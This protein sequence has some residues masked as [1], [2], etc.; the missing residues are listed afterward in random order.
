LRTE[1]AS[2]DDVAQA[3]GLSYQ[4]I[5]KRDPRGVSRP[6]QYRCVKDLG[7]GQI[8]ARRYTSREFIEREVEKVW[9]KTWQY[10]CREEEIPN[11]GDAYVFD[12]VGRSLIVARQA[13][14]GVR[15]FRNAC[16]H[17]GRT[18]LTDGGCKERFRCAYHGLAWNIDGSFRENP[19][20]WDFTHVG[21]DQLSLPQ[22]RVET[23]AGFVF[24]NFD[25]NAEPLLPLLGELPAHLDYWRIADCYKAAHIG[26][27]VPANWKVVCEAF[28]EGFH[29][30]A[31][32]PQASGYIPSEKAQYDV[33]SDH[34]TRLISIT[35]VPGGV[36]DGPLL[37][38]DRVI[39]TM[40]GVGS[41]S[42]APGAAMPDLALKPGQT[43]RSLMA[44]VGRKALQAETG[45]DFSD[46][47]DA[48]LLDGISYDVFPNFAPWGGFAQKI[49]YR[50]RP[51]GLDHERT[52]FEVMLLKIA[53]K[54]GPRPEPARMRLLAADEQWAS[55]TELGYLAGIFD[56]DEANMGPVQDGLRAM[57]EDGMLT[58]SRY[59]DMRCRNLHR[60][61]DAYLAR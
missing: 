42:T 60:M 2:S 54:D 32:H 24:V 18:L 58:F 35:G 49:V 9:L 12:L 43:A 57:G 30:A 51:A 11:P 26:K 31:T 52:L 20:A 10:A 14:G 53:P 39:K 22:A 34:V 6:L 36:S 56:Q 45:Y 28:L 61:I 8:A 37:D 17:R 44:E 59:Q 29:V 5:L 55:A 21:P 23:W 33:L 41:R 15:A 27:V 40:L 16:L 19:F 13:D 50:F 48:D 47:P 4:D 7:A 1:H 25:P 3:P 46:A 38:E